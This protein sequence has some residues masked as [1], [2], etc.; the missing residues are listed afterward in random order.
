MLS[1]TPKGT[2]RHLRPNQAAIDGMHVP[3]TPALILFPR[4]GGEMQAAVRPV[5]APEVFVRL[6]QASTNYVALGE[7]GFQALGRLVSNVPARAIDYPTTAS[8]LDLVEKLWAEVS[9]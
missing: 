8:A 2:I 1:G 3:A 4:F 6:T 5:G 9:G 7:R